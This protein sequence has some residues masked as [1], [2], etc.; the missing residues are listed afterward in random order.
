MQI[1]NKIPR[2]EFPYGVQ[3]VDKVID[4]SADFEKGR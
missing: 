2:T 4:T 3:R 1:M